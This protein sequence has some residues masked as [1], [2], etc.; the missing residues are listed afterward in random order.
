[1]GVFLD[2]P[3][4]TMALEVEA[5]DAVETVKNKIQRKFGIPQRQQQLVLKADS[6]EDGQTLSD[7]GVQHEDTLQLVWQVERG[8]GIFVRTL[9]NKTFDLEVEASDTIGNV[10]AKIRYQKGMPPD[11][12]R[13]IFA[14]KEMKDEQ[15]LSDSNIQHE[16]TLHLVL[17]RIEGYQIYVKTPTGK[18]ITL[19]VEA[20]DTIENVKTK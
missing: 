6:W 18:T 17:R 3:S 11:Q 5:N 1:M 19:K 14:G 4:S 10:K 9:T 2:T 8:M 16:S 7:C 15:T 12:Q 20:I 13:L